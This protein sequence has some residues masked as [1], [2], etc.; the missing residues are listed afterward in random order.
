MAHGMGSSMRNVVALFT[1]MYEGRTVLFAIGGGTGGATVSGGLVGWKGG[2]GDRGG[3][4]G[5]TGVP[6]GDE[7]C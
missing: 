5:I 4:C 1:D 3:V 7:V 6:D 2:V